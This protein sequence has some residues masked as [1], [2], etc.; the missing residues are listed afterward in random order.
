MKNVLRLLLILM[1]SVIC[2]H[3]GNQ[4]MLYIYYYMAMF[5][6]FSDGIMMHITNLH[7]VIRDM[8]YGSHR[9]LM[10]WLHIHVSH[11]G[12]WLN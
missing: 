7:L 9:F 5:P 11:C 12:V 2:F 3:L 10:K 1:C 8:T 6:E 4:Y